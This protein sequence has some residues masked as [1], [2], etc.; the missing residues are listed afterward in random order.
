MQCHKV[1]GRSSL[2]KSTLA[3][4]PG[5]RAAFNPK[6]DPIPAPPLFLQINKTILINLFFSFSL[7]FCFLL[8]FMIVIIN[9]A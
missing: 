2:V 4:R 1:F 3:S 8:I 5:P 6:A 7:F 9:E